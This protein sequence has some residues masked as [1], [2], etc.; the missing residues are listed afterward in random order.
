MQK[1]NMCNKLD[2]KKYVS[3]KVL[4]QMYLNIQEENEKIAQKMFT[5]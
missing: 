4:I 5:F 3:V 2:M 1:H